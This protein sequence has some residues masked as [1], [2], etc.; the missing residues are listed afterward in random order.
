MAK[1]SA[2]NLDITNEAD[3]VSI[4]GGTVRRLL[5]WLG[6]DITLTGSGT[7]TY[8]FPSATD[9]LIGRASTDT[10]TNKTI[11]ANGTGNS[12][13]NIETADIASGS[14]TGLDADLVT[15][16]AGT[17]NDLA[18]WNS[19]GDLID[20]PTPPSGAIVGTSDSQTLTNKT[21]TSPVVNTSIS[22]TAF[23]DEDDMASNSNNKVASQQSIKAYVDA[24]AP[25]DGWITISTIPTRQSADL[26]TYVLRF[27]ADMTAILS[28]GMK[29][30]IT[31]STVKYAIITAV[32]SFSGG[33]TDITIY[34]GTD[35]TIADTASTAITAIWYSMVKSPLGFPLAKS[36]WTLS[37]SDSSYRSQSTPTQNVWYNPGTITL[38]IHIGTWD[39]DYQAD[40]QFDDT[41]NGANVF[42]TLSTANNSESNSAMT[43]AFGVGIARAND[44]TQ[45][46]GKSGV[47]TVASKTTHYLNT[48][49]NNTNVDRIGINGSLTPTIIRA[50]CAYL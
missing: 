20:G 47:I 40:A 21:L 45:L 32:S 2:V 6:A 46:L 4:I 17:A 19:D 9:T 44:Y 37:A 33:N 22:G 38:D 7:N 31:Q 15:G 8:T 42:L 30:K 50:I 39:V 25:G 29:L 14:K 48:K 5:K 13:T 49:T 11:D 36:K 18:I 41:A 16:T 3:G 10:L 27:A 12:I 28:V 35:Y 1:N 24:K 34:C 26:P 23:L 43:S